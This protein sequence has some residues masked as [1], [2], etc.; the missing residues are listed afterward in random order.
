MESKLDMMGIEA[1]AHT[2]NTP[3]TIRLRLLNAL[4]LCS[5]LVTKNAKTV[6]KF[7]PNM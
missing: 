2:S 5:N 1:M 4:H 7:L 6:S 3:H